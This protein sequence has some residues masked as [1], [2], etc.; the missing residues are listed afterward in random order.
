MT[1]LT[2]TFIIAKGGEGVKDI[3]AF[4]NKEMG[5]D[6]SLIKSINASSINE[7]STFLTL[8]Y[9]DQPLRS[10]E[11]T[12]PVNGL[13]SSTTTP[14]FQ[15]FIQYSEP[16]QTGSL[17][18]GSQQFLFN[19]NYINPS[20][21]VHVETGCA[22][23]I[24]SVNLSGSFVGTGPWSGSNTLY[25]DRSVLTD[26]SQQQSTSSLFGFNLV[27][28]AAPYIGLESLYTRDIKRGE[29][30][31]KYAIIDS[32][33]TIDKKIKS[34]LASLAAGGELLS[35]TSTQKSPTQTELFAVVL[36]KPEPVPDSVYPR[37]GS[38]NLA[39][40]PLQ[41]IT[42]SYKNPIKTGQAATQAIYA[43]NR[44]YGSTLDIPASYVNILNDKTLSIDIEQFYIDRT[45]TNNF[46]SLICKP[47]LESA[48]SVGGL[49]S[50]RPYLLPFGTF[51]SEVSIGNIDLSF[52]TGISGLSGIVGPQ[53]PPGPSGAS[54]L[55][56]QQGP[57]GP[58]GVSG[59]SGLQGP[60][61]P[62][63]LS[64]AIGP[65]GLSG[66]IGPPGPSGASGLSGQQGPQGI[67][68]ISG[69]QGLQGLQGIPGADGDPGTV[70]INVTFA[71]DGGIENGS[72]ADVLFP[73]AGTIQSWSM[74]STI[75]GSIE[76]DVRVT[77]SG[78]Y[79]PEVGDSIVAAAP[80]AL[81]NQQ[82]NK[83]LLLPG[84]DTDI[85][86]FDTMRVIVNSDAEIIDVDYLLFQLEILKEL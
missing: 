34:V 15:Y 69:L 1:T 71:G 74:L 39:E 32:S 6:A 68:G 16:I 57:P 86:A 18:D 73:Y 83:N 61:G 55:S 30:D 25:L 19:S 75:T 17:V 9:I 12:N 53:G 52:L 37:L 13:V 28:Q 48:G 84:W 7:H 59:L 60:I 85:Q 5:R 81:V 22:N 31:I 20:T 72:Y 44:S 63:G 3:T 62:S 49:E 58:S 56:G 78:F 43:V 54:G 10:I 29:I 76:L 2:K 14:P 23:Y 77:Y 35:F 46:V 27:Q 26:D 82:A 67:Q 50:S 4:I 21:G 36:T 8:E 66:M 80:P 41:A 38:M 24:I 79:P 51:V 65:S 70:Y 40:A 47:G 42:L 11:I 33:V 64:G 45:I